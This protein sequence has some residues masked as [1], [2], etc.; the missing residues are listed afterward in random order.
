MG[1]A[2]I[3]VGGVDVLRFVVS[4]KDERKMKKE[5]RIFRYVSRA[6]FYSETI[7]PSTGALISHFN[8]TGTGATFCCGPLA[9]SNNSV[10]CSPVNG[11]SQYPFTLAQGTLIPGVAALAN[12]K[13][14]MSMSMRMNSSHESTAMCSSMTN[15][16]LN[17]VGVGVGV[18][19]GVTTIAALLWGLYERRRRKREA[20]AAAAPSVPVFSDSRTGS[21]MRMGSYP[22][23]FLKR[24]KSAYGE[25]RNY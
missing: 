22:Q 2:P 7:E 10:T 15:L 3:R 4:L 5:S 14:I 25:E 18:P 8:G 19:L 11:Q 16:K 6:D 1:V 12:S 9:S 13:T 20:V 24:V 17:T 23:R 21:G